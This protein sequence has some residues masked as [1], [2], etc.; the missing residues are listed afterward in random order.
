MKYFFIL[1]PGSRSGASE[2]SFARLQHL[3]KW[4]SIEYEYAVTKDLDEAYSLSAQGNRQG[5][6]SIVAVGGDGTIN[7]VLNGFYDKEGRRISHAAL[8]VIYTGTSPDFCKNYHIPLRRKSAVDALI[9]NK[10]QRIP[11][12]KITYAQD[13][14]KRLHKES[15]AHCNNTESR[16]FAL[17]ANFGM[18]PM[19]AHYANTGMRN[20][21]G[22]YTGTLFS[23]LRS[24][25]SYCPGDFTL[26]A[27][28]KREVAKRVYNISVGR[29]YYI[30]SGLKI[31]HTLADNREYFYT[32]I[33]RNVNYVNLWSILKMLYRGD[34]IKNNEVI[35][36]RYNRGIEIY[37][38][39]TNPRIEFDG[40]PAAG[41]LPCK[42][43][44]ARDML[45]IIV[46]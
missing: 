34:E 9:H 28:E 18:G 42:I 5:Y 22:D 40:D 23:L 6:D 10:I 16:Y 41:Y 13:F 30:A 8:G 44:M 36:L 26:Y 17:C 12:G 19:I 1:N 45:D 33:V 4:C 25:L 2:K 46:E 14:D 3:L 15:I 20:I 32:M 24:L 11:I 39:V 29:S 37:G 43:E 31:K 38:N 27:D 35:S 7:R 21:F